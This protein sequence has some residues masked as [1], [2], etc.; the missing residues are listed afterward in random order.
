MVNA[1]KVYMLKLVFKLKANKSLKLLLFDVIAN[2][3][4]LI[5]L[6]ITGMAQ[7]KRK[8]FIFI[9]V[10]QVRVENQIS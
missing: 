5:G 8:L 9:V 7:N 4:I 1:A 2:S 3:S 6:E 10:S